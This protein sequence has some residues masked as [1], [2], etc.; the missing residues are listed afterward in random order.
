MTQGRLD[1]K[2]ALV[3]GA[4]SGIGR[5]SAK[6]L[7]AR[8][9]RVACADLNAAGAES[10]A[11]EIAQAGG[12]AFGLALDV[13]DRAANERA[14]AEVVRRYG[15]LHLAHL[16]AGIAVGSSVLDTPLEEW[17][18]TLAVN[19]T[20][21]FLGLQSAARAMRTAGGGSIVITSSDAGLRGG[22]K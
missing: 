21:V 22:K 2:V 3:T 1:G 10:V 8:G 9:A 11:K 15:A 4:A 6:E 14:V 20:G 13:A 16:N 18:R 19:L 17:S 7:A 12:D 5:A